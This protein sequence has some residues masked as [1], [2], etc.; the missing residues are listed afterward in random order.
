MALPGRSLDSRPIVIGGCYRSGTS[1][2][3]R[4]LDSH[5]AIHCGP[6][7]K[8]F[9]DFYNQY[10]VD[11]PTGPVR[12][13]FSARSVLPDPD[14][15]EI[16][17]AAFVSIHQRAAQ[18]AGKRRWADKC[19]ENV[20]YT[21]EWSSLL[22]DDWVL[23]HVVRN[24]LDTL[25]S[26]KEADW[27]DALPANFDSRIDVYIR[28]L[29]AGIAFGAAHPARYRMILYEELVSDPQTVLSALMH[30]L[31]EEFE[32][33]QLSFNS[34]P[35]QLGLEDMK[36]LNTSEVHRDSIGRWR[37]ILTP[38][39]SRQVVDRTGSLWRTADCRRRYELPALL[40]L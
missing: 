17:G 40:H 28:Y 33:G 20:L 5:S 15:L 24:P 31:N 14:L 25:A 18:I 35:H 2:V 27:Q 30:W 9:L 12:F 4:L 38:D 29:E 19:P 10:T 8:F 11:D 13:L 1:L 21:A 16:T 39:E 37:E 23:L 36:I 32:S 7:I 34:R 3:R 26:I 6:E 22:G